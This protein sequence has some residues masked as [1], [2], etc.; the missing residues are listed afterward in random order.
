MFY[1]I[2]LSPQMKRSAIVSYKHGKYAMSYEL[3]NYL[4][5][6]IL[7]NKEVARKSPVFLVKRK[8]C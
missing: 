4:R 6:R 5:L 1:Q 7:G 2:F 8:F 3:P